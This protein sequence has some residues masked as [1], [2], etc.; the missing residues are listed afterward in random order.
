MNKDRLKIVGQVFAIV[1]ALSMIISAG[2][3]L[4]FSTTITAASQGDT[5]ESSPF[6]TMIRLRTNT[7]DPLKAVPELPTILST[8]AY[9]TWVEA[10][11][12][13]QAEEPITE[14]WKSEL[15]K[16]GVEIISYIPDNALLVRMD[17]AT[18]AVAEALPGIRWSGNLEPAYKI[19]PEL[20]DMVGTISID[21]MLFTEASN[22]DIVQLIT[23]LAGGKIIALTNTEASKLVRAEIDSSWLTLLASQSEVKWISEFTQPKPMNDSTVP[24]LQSGGGLRPVHSQGIEGLDEIITVSD[25]GLNTG[26]PNFQASIYTSSGNQPKV[27]ANYI[28]PTSPA[29]MGDYGSYHGTHTSGTTSGDGPTYGTWQASTYDGHAFMDQLV[30]QDIGDSSQPDYVFPPSDYYNYLFGDSEAYGSKFHS[31]SWGGGSTYGDD[32]VQIDKYIWDSQDYTIC[33][34]AGNDGTSEPPGRQAEAKNE[35]TVGGTS[36][37][38]GSMYGSSTRGPCDDGRLFPDV[39]APAVSVTS[40]TS[41]TGYVGM[42][43]TSMACPAGA[44]CAALVRE[45]YRTGWYPTGTQ[46]GANGWNPSAA[47]IKATLVN[48]AVDIG[49]AN[50]PNNNEGWGR[51]HLD[52]A[53][54]FAGD[55]RENMVIDQTEGMVTGGFFEYHFGV[56]DASQPFR[57]TLVWTDFPGDPI[58]AKMLVNDLDLTVVAPGGTTY[59]GNVFSGGQSTTGG[60]YDSLNVIECV[61]RNSPSTGVYT[62]RIDAPTVAMGPQNFALVVT[63]NHDDGYGRVTMD[64]PVYNEADTINLRVEDLNTIGVTVDVVV[65]GSISGDQ[66]TVSLT[67]TAVNSGVYLGTLDTDIGLTNVEDGFLQVYHGETITATYTDGDPPHSDTATALIDIAKPVITNVRA[68]NI[69]GTSAIIKWDTNENADSV[70]HYREFGQPTFSTESDLSLA[71]DHAVPLLGLLENTKYEYYVESTDWLG[72]TAMDDRNGMYYTFRTT[73]ALTGGALI[74]YVDDDDGTPSNTGDPFEVDWWNNFDLYGWTYSTWDIDALQASPTYTDLNQAPMIIWSCADGYPV[75]GTDDRNALEPYLD[76]ALTG[77]GTVPMC[78]I[79]GQ[80]TGWDMCDGSGTD[81]DPT[82]YNNYL[83]ADYRQDS[84]NEPNSEDGGEGTESSSRGQT[85]TVQVLDVGHALNIYGYDNIDLEEDA[86]D[87]GGGRFWPDDINTATSGLTGETS[88]IVMDYNVH[89]STTSGNPGNAA[90]VCQEAGGAAG[91][92][93][94]VYNAFSHEMIASTN[95]GGNDWNPPS[96]DTERS[97]MC[98]QTIQWLLGGNHPTIDLTNP[99]GGELFTGNSITVTW[100]VSG[101]ASIDLYYSPNSGQEYIPLAT[102]LAGSTISYPWDITGY[103]DADTYRV[104]VV[105]LGSAIYATLTDFSESLDFEIDHGV[106]TLPPITIPGS[107]QTSVNPITAGTMI[108]LTATIDDSQMGKSVITDAEW[109]LAQLGDGP[110]WPSGNA[111]NPAD[112]T[113]N[114]MTED[115]TVDIDTTGW[116]GGWYELW[117]RGRDAAGNWAS[118]EKTDVFVIGGA[119][120]P[121]DIPIGGTGWQFISFPYVMSG[122]V[123]TVFD[124]TNGDGGTTWTMI[125]YYDGSDPTDHWKTYYTAVPTLSD[126]PTVDQNKGVWIY[127]TANGGDGVLTTGTLGDYSGAAVVVPLEIGWNL[128][129]YPTATPRQAQNTLPGGVTKLAVYNGAMT[130]NIEEVA[131][132][133]TMSE[134]NAYWVYSTD[135]ADWTCNT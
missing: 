77:G 17:E 110:T 15:N 130:Y 122:D 109:C 120:F 64:R 18:K 5:V 132:T 103:E 93:R 96:T 81:Q 37:D 129:G 41:G 26:H 111:M 62:V 87:P 57:A 107:V 79:V 14:P 78:W 83:C 131:L 97:G 13:I 11:Y 66:E 36:N 127:I 115:V 100:T 119:G 49:T 54:F 16:A 33:F 3:F 28:P 50:I 40:C 69:L 4:T 51:I 105:A 12:I 71:V 101:A 22:N 123:I 95:N 92:A 1:V 55:A 121:Y 70:V 43:G 85:G 60:T 39:L 91:A 133:T 31:N 52:N 80:D 25:S 86:F 19:S 59:R 104:K 53:L 134:G 116:L 68:E 20:N 88:Q 74:L 2:A 76:Q 45:Y 56:T 67:R 30:M 112:G 126:M 47:L 65:T 24:L 108:T 38:G 84:C 72:R 27:L 35:I 99:T 124:D 6:G 29:N 10:P 135:G 7:F 58:A 75:I 118:S 9:P 8:P 21:I 106:D 44:G 46:I 94:I 128:V 82:W 117:V 102:G 23:K 98:D 61:Y 48:G 125:Q 90:I 114:T 63:A 34:A 73:S 89:D 32:S 42:S 113:F